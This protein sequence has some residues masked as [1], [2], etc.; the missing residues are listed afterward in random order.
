MSS[1]ADSDGKR[2]NGSVPPDWCGNGGRRLAAHGGYCA[3]VLM[4]T[5]QQY[6]HDQNGAQGNMEPLNMSV[7]YLEPL[8]Q[9]RFEIAL[10]T[11]S[12][13]KRTSTVE[14]RLKSLEAHEDKLCTIVIVRL[15]ILKD[16]GHVTNIQP[17]VWPL[18]DRTKDCARWSDASYYYM[19]PPASTV[20]MWT[21]SGENVPL[22]SERFGGQNTR[23]QWVKL[24]NEKKFGLEHLPVL[25]DLVPPIFLNYTENGMEAAS[26]WGIPTTAL[27]I[28]FR[29]EVTRQDCLLTRTTMKRLHGGRFDMNIEILNE[30]GKL[31]ASCVQICSVIPLEKSSSQAGGKL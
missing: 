16:E 30:D 11:L 20:R 28:M 25:A 31:L 22:W 21:P 4:M 2:Y 19:N 24:D 9:G 12:T 5:A 15:G 26:S 14:A 10:E 8:P 7:E 23:Y 29:S 27:N 6:L 3:T 13:G 17:P 1:V 18:P